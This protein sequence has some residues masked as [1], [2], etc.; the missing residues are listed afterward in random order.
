M[1]RP[2]PITRTTR[3]PSPAAGGAAGL[4]RLEDAAG[5]LRRGGQLDPAHARAWRCG[6]S[7]SENWDRPRTRLK[8]AGAAVQ[9]D[10]NSPE[11]RRLRGAILSGTGQQA[12]ALAEMD[13]AVALRPGDSGAYKDRGAV[14]SR[15][16]QYEKAL[17]DLDEAIRLDPRNARAYQNRAGTYNEMRQFDRAL[18]DCDEAIKLDPRNAGARNNRGLAL[19]GLGKNEQAIADLTDAI[20]LNPRLTPAYVNRG[21]AYVKIGQLGEAVADYESALQLSPGLTVV[22]SGLRQVHD[23]LKLR[24]SGGDDRLAARQTSPAAARAMSDGNE[25][26]ASGDWAGAVAD[27]ARAVE[28]DPRE[29][30]AYALRG[31]AAFCAGLPGA[32]ADARAWL[33]LKGWRDPLAPYM[34]LLG[35]LDARRARHDAA[36][37]AFLDEALAN[38]SPAAWPAP[39]FRYL[40]RSIKSSDLISAAEGRERLTEA[41]AVI[42]IDLY[43][44]GERSAASDHLR[45]VRDHGEEGSIARDAAVETLKR[46]EAGTTD[47]P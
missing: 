43:L 29:A 44:R 2:S 41:R 32:E 26:R 31:W 16:G 15:S 23:L 6:P 7:R 17:R 13:A 40:K 5:E 3:T 34:A 24:A 36:S 18:A 21:N 8:D 11:A 47:R 30:E 25:S 46:I 19:I 22:E 28:A 9:A 1:N 35:S 39:V 33:D 20:R 42:G 45:W 4:G 38:V 10:P 14:L 12:A 37:A 27:Y